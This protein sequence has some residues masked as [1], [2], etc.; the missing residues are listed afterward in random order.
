MMGRRDR[1]EYLRAYREGNREKA[2]QTTREW[3]AA[4]PERAK[5]SQRA[6]YK[7]HRK[8][9]QE[10]QRAYRTANSAK[11]MARNK[12]WRAANPGKAIVHDA[13]TLLAAATGLPIRQVPRALALAK[14]AQLGVIRAVRAAQGMQLREDSRSEAQGEARQPGSRSECAPKD[15]P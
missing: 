11:A 9:R 14:A 10:A 13:K 12:A 5:A 8:K 2:R 4:N 6:S 7:R 1:T 3:R 15:T